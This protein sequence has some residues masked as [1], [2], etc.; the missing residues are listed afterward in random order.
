MMFRQ[1]QSFQDITLGIAGVMNCANIADT[2]VV[3][4]QM[5]GEHVDFE[6]KTVE[7]NKYKEEAAKAIEDNDK[8][9]ADVSCL[10]A[11]M[12]DVVQKFSKY[13]IDQQALLIMPLN[14]LLLLEK[15]IIDDD[16]EHKKETDE[17]KHDIAKLQA[18]IDFVEERA[19]N[20]EELG[21]TYNAVI[22]P[23]ETE[24]QVESMAVDAAA[25]TSIRNDDAS[26]ISAAH[27]TSAFATQ[28]N[29]VPKG[30]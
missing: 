11:E 22:D 8:A 19:Q 12:D 20:D 2:V 17:F 27:V 28:D 24:D 21:T 15:K 30:R 29:I 26:I 13:K 18:F 1:L 9:I 14:K 5:V 7:I 6:A 10:I 25:T 3:V 4:K 23:Y 16:K